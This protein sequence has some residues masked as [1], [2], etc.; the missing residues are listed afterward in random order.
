MSLT[1]VYLTQIA[2]IGWDSIGVTPPR[3]RASI[4]WRPL[5]STTHFA[6]TSTRSPF[7]RSTVTRLPA[8][9]FNSKAVTRAGRQTSVP[10]SAAT[11]NRCSSSFDRSSWKEGVR[12]SC[13]GPTSDAS[14][15]HVTF[16]LTNQ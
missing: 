15:R 4:A 13:V 2:E 7:S 14:R 11:F 10:S 9:P 16:S 1:P 3:L 12:A 6:E 8:S 5:A